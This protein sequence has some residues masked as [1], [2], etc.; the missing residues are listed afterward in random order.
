MNPSMLNHSTA[1]E[2]VLDLRAE[3]NQILPFTASGTCSYPE[4]PAF[5]LFDSTEQSGVE[6]PSSRAQQWQLGAPGIRS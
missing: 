6:G 5:I 2:E 4:R 3:T 1:R